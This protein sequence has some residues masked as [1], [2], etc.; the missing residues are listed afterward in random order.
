MD[1]MGDFLIYF[2]FVILAAGGTF[3]LGEWIW[4]NLLFP[5][6]HWSVIIRTDGSVECEKCHRSLKKANPKWR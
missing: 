2:W 6:K 3:K 5:C 1:F 4:K